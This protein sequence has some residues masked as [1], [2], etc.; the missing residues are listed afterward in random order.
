M[1]HRDLEKYIIQFKEDLKIADTCKNIRTSILDAITQGEYFSPELATYFVRDDEKAPFKVSSTD[2]SQVAVL[3]KLLNALENVEKAI[4]RIEHLD[5]KRNRY[6]IGIYKD[7]V[8]AGY[9]AVHEVAAALELIN[10][11][12]SDIQ[13]IVAPHI[14]DLMPKMAVAANALGQFTPSKPEESAGA[15]LAGVIQQLPH[16]KHTKEQSLENLSTFIFDLP[17]RFEALQKLVAT[18]ASGIA[19]KSITSPEDYQKAMIQR[20]N[21][22]K[23]YFE[24]LSTKSGILG[25]PSYI[26]VIRKL[27]AHSTDLVNT[28]APLT[29]QAYLDAADKLNE[30]K[31]DLLPQLLAELEKIEEG[32]SLKPGTLTDPVLEQ[33]NTYYT[34]LATQVEAIAQTAGVLDSATEYMDSNLGTLVRYLVKDKGSLDVGEKIKPIE[35]LTV[36]MD[37]RFVEKRKAN[38]ATRLNEARFEAEDNTAK[39]AATRFFDR[40]NSYNSIHQA[41]CKWSL[42]NVSQTER[43]S[44]LAD[45]KQFQPHF[46]AMHPGVDKLI[47]DA[48]TLPTGTNIVSRLWSSEYKQLYGSNHFSKVLACKND[49]IEHIEQSKAQADFKARLIDNTMSHAEEVAYETND[50]TTK[51]STSVQP[52]VPHVLHFEEGKPAE[53]Y[54]KQGIVAANHVTK[55]EQ[56]RD[57]VKQFF[58]YL[59]EYAQQGEPPRN[60]VN[61]EPL[62]KSLTAEDKEFLR[63]QYKKFQPQLVTMGSA[64]ERLNEQL[65]AILNSSTPHDPKDPPLYL[66]HVIQ[67]DTLIDGKLVVLEAKAKQDRKTYLDKEQAQKKK[68]V[69]SEPLTA[70]GEE[71]GKKTL[72]GMLSELKLSQS[73]DNFL[74]D[75]FQNYLKENLSPEVWKQLPKEIGTDKLDLDPKNLPYTPL[76]KDSEEVVMYKQLINSLHYMRVG[77][78]E[79]EALNNTADSTNIF[80][81]AW[82]L[83][84]AFSALLQNINT[85]KFHLL[86]AAG[87]PG[88]KAIL[89]E[90]LDLLEPIKNIPILGDYVKEPMAKSGDYLN[91]PN[92]ASQID[93][94]QAWK[95]QQKIVERGLAD[96]APSETT[97]AIAVEEQGPEDGPEPKPISYVQLIAE[98]LYQLP[99]A[100]NRLNG[101]DDVSLDSKEE[102]NKQIKSF[103]DGLNGLSFGPGTANKVLNTIAKFQ[104]QVSE[105]GALSHALALARLKEIR[106]EFGAIFME[107]ADSA[108]FHLGLK[109]GAYSDVVKERFDRFYEALIVNVSTEFKKDQDGL[110]LLLDLSDSQKRLTREEN[111]KK[112]VDATNFA[113]VAQGMLTSANYNEL[114]K[115]I[116]AFDNLAEISA[117]DNLPE[118]SAESD[119]PSSALTNDFPELQEKASR[120]YDLIQLLLA[121]VDPKFTAD[122]IDNAYDESNLQGLLEQVIAVQDQVF[123]PTTTFEQFQLFVRESD[124]KSEEDQKKFLEYYVE[125]QPYLRKIDS[126][127]NFNSYL[128]E[129]QD[130]ADFKA[131]GKKIVAEAPKLQ[132]LIQG[133]ADAKELKLKLCDERINH[134][135]GMIKAQQEVIGPQKIEAFKE[136]F[137]SN[138]VNANLKRL[139]AE[140]GSHAEAFFDYILPEISKKKAEIV[141]GIDINLDMEA[142]ITQRIDDASKITISEQKESFKSVLFEQQ[143]QE[144]VKRSEGESL[145]FYTEV[146]LKEIQPD[147]KQAKTVAL[148]GIEFNE[149]MGEKIAS[150]VGTVVPLVLDINKNMQE[151]LSKLNK[152]LDKVNE[153]IKQEQ[154]FAD[155]NPCRGTKLATLMKVNDDLTALDLSGQENKVDYINEA[156]A[157]AEKTIT[158]AVSYDAIINI[159]D[160]LNELKEKIATESMAP[161]EKEKRLKVISAIQV[162]LADET[163]LPSER[164]EVALSRLSAASEQNV[165][166]SA[167]HYLVGDAYKGQLFDNHLNITL[168][169]QMQKE[170]GPYTTAFIQKVSSDFMTKKSE[171]I[172]DLAVDDKTEE[173]IA[174]KS[175]KDWVDV[176]SKNQ[177][178]KDLCILLS[179]SLK[180][181]S[182]VIEQEQRISNANPG[183]PGRAEKIRQ[184]ENYQRILKDENIP[185]HEGMQHLQRRKEELQDFLARVPQ[186]DSIIK[187]HDGL[188]E[189][190]SYVNSKETSVLIK[191]KKIEEIS[192]MQAMLEVDSK[193]PSE[194]LAEVKSHGLSE[195]CQEVLHQNSDNPF[196]KLIKKF[197]SFF[198]GPSQEETMMSSFKQRLQDIKVPAVEAP[199]EQNNINLGM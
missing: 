22:T 199:K 98:K 80:T 7:L 102:V 141:A 183:N 81:R 99:V 65:V 37:E 87:N 45:Y 86:E 132:E 177:D 72:F 71:V 167:N 187:V 15:L 49:V 154:V 135:H 56:A 50:K 151:A 130:P 107:A 96:R 114:A 181:I 165:L 73:V 120:A 1:N 46:A 63:V 186:Y 11:S 128:R 184:L 59:R 9:N 67:Q 148:N 106:S 126:L 174:E 109:P 2:P 105:I 169:E 10:H 83:W 191:D 74:Q 93:V 115:Q 48:L 70:K 28:A 163:S 89:H 60:T 92:E 108:E 55:L 34:Q 94:I 77:L 116:S 124:F 168:A 164:L 173:Q 52:Y 125:F 180:I 82:H 147:Y 35:G 36:M 139:E 137:F 175:K 6:K 78:K 149:K 61:D 131:Q 97:V 112:D 79:L 162:G 39:E 76:H 194:R 33:M 188:N 113:E 157:Q 58:D 140:L 38:Q 190:K 19:T 152:T 144:A 20:A 134:L 4:S 156:N 197:V 159:Y 13:E 14:K 27:I 136:K 158:E 91:A 161:L 18:G 185:R 5:I 95:D 69:T 64:Y 68:E 66:A 8:K 118:I 88:L 21:E 117:F 90:G 24:K 31:H 62:F 111:R 170:L 150:S 3:K 176:C 44:F 127:Y 16:T 84:G 192:K 17:R 121:E 47:V 26:G 155:N 146:F 104:M 12:S 145:G 182:Q 133:L 42:A 123:K 153:L 103:V 43:E 54:H 25:L 110:A 41:L 166:R 53:H 100:L 138:Y 198:T 189:M 23:E 30:I 178:A 160:V 142:V 196:V 122:F 51:L 32:M 171:I 119:V 179:Q 172:K 85:S 29:K 101:V 195:K 40:L 143:V 75:K 129:L 57:G 193:D